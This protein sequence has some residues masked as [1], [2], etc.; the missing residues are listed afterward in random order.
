MGN[1]LLKPIPLSNGEPSSGQNEV[2]IGWHL[3]PDAWGHGYTTEAAR[4]AM[5][6]AFN[7]GLA[8]VIAVTDP[9]NHAS[10]SVCERLEI[11]PLGRTTRY[12][13]SVNELF[14]RVS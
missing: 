7:R 10:Q 12:Y 6:D 9:D 8:R 1:I 5:D 4:A 14:E 11:T 2:E 13:D 3:H